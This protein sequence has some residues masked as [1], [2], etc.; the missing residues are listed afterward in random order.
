[1][2]A[3][4]SLWLVPPPSSDQATKLSDL[5]SNTIPSLFPNIKLP[6]F[7]PHVTLVT[8]ID[9]ST[10][11]GESTQSWLDARDLNEI[12][13]EDVKIDFGCVKVG[14]MFTKR[15]YLQVSKSEDLVNFAAQL[16]SQIY[17]ARKEDEVYKIVMKEWDPHL[18]LL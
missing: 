9:A 12:N 11:A 17:G 18:S 10:F 1:M 2:S 13:A 3:R 8:G 16:L 15:C 6:R 7:A 14:E 5:L 4:L